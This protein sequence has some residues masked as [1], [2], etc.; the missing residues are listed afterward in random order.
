MPIYTL[1]KI[2]SK[3][4]ILD[5]LSHHL[6][7]PKEL[8]RFL[9]ST[10]HSM[11]ELFTDNLAVILMTVK[12]F[13]ADIKS[14][15]SQGR[16]LRKSIKDDSKVPFLAVCKLGDYLIALDQHG[17]VTVYDEE[18]RHRRQGPISQHSGFACM[19]RGRDG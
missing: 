14:H 7:S 1:G 10:S 13:L 12:H 2:H 11:R 19:C 6:S 4:L 18:T 5:I 15:V 8:S 16:L 9:F 3:Y 17:Q